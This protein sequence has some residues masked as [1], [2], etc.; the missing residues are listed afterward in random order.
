MQTTRM[1]IRMLNVRI[2]L[3]SLNPPSLHADI[4]PFPRKVLH[5]R[6]K[7]I[8]NGEVIINEY[9]SI[10]KVIEPILTHHSH[11]CASNIL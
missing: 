1:Q 10:N 6:T 5:N 7:F 9:E 3:L 11:I 4:G 8:Y 2:Y